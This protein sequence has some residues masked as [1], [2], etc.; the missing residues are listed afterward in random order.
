MKRVL[1]LLNHTL[2]ADQESE[3]KDRWA[4]RDIVTLP[5]DLQQFWSS[6]NP[7]TVPNTQDLAELQ[8]W[9]LYTLQPNDYLII[10]GEFGMTYYFVDFAFKHGFIPLYAA[11]ERVYEGTANPDGSIERKHVFRHVRFKKYRRSDDI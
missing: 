7:A 3:L 1:K 2:T 8:Q 6:I 11:T 5:V 10:Q 9:I 4:C